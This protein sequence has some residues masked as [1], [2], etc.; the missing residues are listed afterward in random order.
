MVHKHSYV[1]L[2]YKSELEAMTD[3]AG[4]QE[5]DRTIQFRF[6]QQ[7][8]DEVDNAANEEAQLRLH[9][10]RQEQ[11]LKLK[12]QAEKRRQEKVLPT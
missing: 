4:L 3:P 5:K 11:G 10:K 6:H 8:V 1:A 2:D 12:A 9:K 7:P